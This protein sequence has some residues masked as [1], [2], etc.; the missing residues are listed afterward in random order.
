MSSVVPV[1]QFKNSIVLN[2]GE[3]HLDGDQAA[4]GNN[5]VYGT[6]GSGN[7]TWKPDPAG[8]GA[9]SIGDTVTGGSNRSILFV[10]SSGNLG[11]SV[12]LTY[13]ANDRLFVGGTG[14]NYDVDVIKDNAVLNVGTFNTS[15]VHFI[16]LGG[17]ALLRYDDPDDTLEVGS[18]ATGLADVWIRS[19]EGNDSTVRQIV[20]RQGRF[21]FNN[22]P[23]SLP[24]S[25]SLS[26]IGNG[27]DNTM[28]QVNNTVRDVFIVHT[29]SG[30]ADSTISIDHNNTLKRVN[31]GAVDS[32]GSGQRLLTVA[33]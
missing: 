18:R 20:T 14:G 23:S 11:Q 30:V 3:Y 31:V 17:E 16:R 15:S 26:F 13:Q 22:N 7:K 19:G 33:N 5:Q 2:Q 32:G 29:S 24:S 1:L 25:T 27:S 8:G 4:P 28:I 9:I 10:D 6:D 12:N 21:F